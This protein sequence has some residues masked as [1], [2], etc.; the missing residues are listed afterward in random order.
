[1]LLNIK[2]W[3]MRILLFCFICLI[4]R[5]IEAQVTYHP[6]KE[7]KLSAEN[8]KKIEAFHQ[9]DP[10]LLKL[11]GKNREYIELPENWRPYVGTAPFR[12]AFQLARFFYEELDGQLEVKVGGTYVDK[13]G[14]YIYAYHILD[15]TVKVID[16]DLYLIP[17]D[18]YEEAQKDLDKLREEKVVAAKDFEQNYPNAIYTETLNLA[19]VDRGTYGLIQSAEEVK[20]GDYV[21]FNQTTREPPYLY[22][23]KV[24]SKKNVK[25][26]QV[27]LLKLIDE[28]LETEVRCE[29]CGGKNSKTADK[30]EY[31]GA[32]IEED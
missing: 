28:D 2:M 18:H 11:E 26:V 6:E 12:S 15:T 7:I 17:F 31:C 24:G 23:V 30:C 20:E 1:M 4:G 29:Y 3:P 13:I 16:L 32:P 25:G 9:Q 21:L 19:K 8:Q 14:K 22:M 10:E 27:Q 5:S